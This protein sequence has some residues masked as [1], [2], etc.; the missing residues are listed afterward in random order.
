MKL[1]KQIDKYRL[2][3]EITVDLLEKQDA[4]ANLAK[5]AYDRNKEAV[6]TYMEWIKGDVFEVGCRHGVLFDILSE[7]KLPITK[8]GIDISPDAIQRARK[9]GYDADLMVAEKL[10]DVTGLHGK[11]DTVFCLHTLEHCINVPVVIKGI[12]ECLK[13]GGHALIEIPIQ[14]KE[15]TP[16]KWGHYYCFA[17]DKE[18]IDMC[19]PPFTYIEMFKKDK[20]T[21]RRYVFRK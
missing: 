21:W 16:T 17:W 18:L 9:K 7:Y 2:N 19:C 6:E 1:K 12:Y 20:R 13:Y 5:A 4:D 15:P 10:V 8:Y 14:P 3:R 11:F